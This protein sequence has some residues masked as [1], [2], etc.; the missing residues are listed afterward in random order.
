MSRWGLLRDLV[1]AEEEETA[2]GFLG[3]EEAGDSE[4]EGERSEVLRG[5]R[6]RGFLA[7]REGGQDALGGHG[8]VEELLLL[9]P[10]GGGPALGLGVEVEAPLAGGDRGRRLRP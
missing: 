4:I 2:L 10:E 9:Q 7:L 6:G 8:E 3:E 5:W 1:G